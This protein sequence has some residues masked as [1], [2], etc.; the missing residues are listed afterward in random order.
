MSEKSEKIA[1]L[2]DTFRSQLLIGLVGGKVSGHYNITANL[3]KAFGPNE[4]MHV[5]R[6]VATFD[7][8]T[9]DNDPYGEHDFGAIQHGDENVFWKI[10]YYDRESLDAGEEYGSEDPS[11]PEITTRVM[12]IMLA[13]DY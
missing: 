10:D 6:K 13:Q 3:Q 11:D 1:D 4:I 7:Q 5:F 12:T 8:F 9:P 2:N